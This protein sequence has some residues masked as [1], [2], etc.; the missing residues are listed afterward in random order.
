MIEL[1]GR[2]KQ[3]QKQNN[4]QESWKNKALIKN[5]YS[6]GLL[7]LSMCENILCENMQLAL[8]GNHK[9]MPHSHYWAL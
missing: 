5:D 2:R 4:N 7:K 6:K 1:G 8:A 9:Y 3:K